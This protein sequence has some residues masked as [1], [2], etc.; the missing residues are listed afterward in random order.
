MRSVDL[1][2]EEKVERNK[3]N[4][5]SENFETNNAIKVVV[6]G[7]GIQEQGV[8]VGDETAFSIYSKGFSIFIFYFNFCFTK[9]N[10]KSN[11]TLN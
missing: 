7:P 8:N 1:E 11:E 9:L 10:P 5:T 3:Y 6:K 2:K 4:K